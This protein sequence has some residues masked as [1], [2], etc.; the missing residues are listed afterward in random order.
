[1]K[2]AEHP[3]HF[4]RKTARPSV[5]VKGRVACLP[6]PVRRMAGRAVG[7]CAAA[8]DRLAATPDTWGSGCV[9]EFALFRAD[10]YTSGFEPAVRVDGPDVPC[11]G[12]AG[13]TRT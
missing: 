3:E 13:L 12:R 10:G 1:M 8:G 5:T 2:L 7:V 9:G 11:P 4:E 6:R